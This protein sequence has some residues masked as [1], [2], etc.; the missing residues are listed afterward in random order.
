MAS[1]KVKNQLIT[2]KFAVYN[3]DCC[4][5]LPGLPDESIGLSVF[6]PP[7]AS[8]YTY[9]DE[10]GDMGNSK[11]LEE[12][13]EH[14]SF[15]VSDFFSKD[16]AVTDKGMKFSIFTAGIY[17]RRKLSQKLLVENSPDK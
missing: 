15:L 10:D 11:S 6:S 2:K 5:V 13:F 14:F 17:C 16:W 4:E 7:F 1:S 9:S 12:F 8:L 3:G